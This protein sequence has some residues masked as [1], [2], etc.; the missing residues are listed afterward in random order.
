MNQMRFIAVFTFGLDRPMTGLILAKADKGTLTHAELAKYY[1]L[2]SDTPMYAGYLTLESGKIF[3]FGG[4]PSLGIFFDEKKNRKVEE[5]VESFARLSNGALFLSDNF[6]Q[7]K[8]AHVML[9]R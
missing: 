5:E 8:L 7:R 6:A 4:S 1:N 9:N 3:T 2:T